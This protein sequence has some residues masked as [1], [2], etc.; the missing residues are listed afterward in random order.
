MKG[1]NQGEGPG[2]LDMALIQAQVCNCLYLH[3]SISSYIKLHQRPS[4]S[5]TNLYFFCFFVLF[6]YSVCWY[7]LLD[8]KFSPRSQR[9]NSIKAH[10]HIEWQIW[11]WRYVPVWPSP[12][13][14]LSFAVLASYAKQLNHTPNKNFITDLLV[15]SEN[16]RKNSDRQLLKT[17][18][19][20]L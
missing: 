1:V 10:Y 20:Y 12:L 8:S 19:L 18:L 11:L 17:V 15:L 14:V 16:D 4:L 3:L 9:F 2:A 5:V 6:V 13:C 7:L